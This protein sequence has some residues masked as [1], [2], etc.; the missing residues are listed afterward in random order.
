MTQVPPNSSL[1]LLVLLLLEG[2]SLHVSLSSGILSVKNDFQMTCYTSCFAVTKTQ[3]KMRFKKFRC[4]SCSSASCC[5]LRV[6][7]H[8]RCR[9]F[10]CRMY[11]VHQG[12]SRLNTAVVAVLRHDRDGPKNN[13]NHDT[14][15]ALQHVC[16]LPAYVCVRIIYSSTSYIIFTRYNLS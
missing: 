2:F 1:V 15:V 16:R 10:R 8:E 11:V 5:A 3:N 7:P 13:S 4:S 9:G 14:P 6:W 12:A